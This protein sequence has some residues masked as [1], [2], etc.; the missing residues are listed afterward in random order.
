MN[1][2]RAI[3]A[4]II[5]KLFALL[6]GT[7]KFKTVFKGESIKRKGIGEVLTW[8]GTAAPWALTVPDL[9]VASE[10]Y[11]KTPDDVL[12][13]AIE[14][15]YFPRDAGSSKSQWRQKFREIGQP[16][17]DL[18][19]GFDAAVLWHLFA[20]AIGNGEIAQYTGMCHE[21][22]EKLRLPI[23]YF[24]TK[25]TEHDRFEFFEPWRWTRTVPLPDVAY[26]AD[27]L[28]NINIERRG[29]YRA[30]MNPLLED[31]KVT[32]MRKAV[33]SVLRIP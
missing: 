7:S 31:E 20:E 15:K 2:E 33:K 22:I 11:H 12:L 18:L 21:V 16:L 25:L 9:I 1:G 5:T 4:K 8:D 23:V 24:A 13:L 27:C 3:E 19:Y 14:T 6:N 29:S 28:R 26:V 32:R 10:N 17:R 30:K